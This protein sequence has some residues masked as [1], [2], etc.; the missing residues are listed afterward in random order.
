VLNFGPVLFVIP[1][2]IE[3]IV[4]GGAHALFLARLAAARAGAAR[5]RAADL[6]RFREMKSRS[7]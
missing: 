3:L 5:Q 7:A 2:P 6:A 1:V 4:I